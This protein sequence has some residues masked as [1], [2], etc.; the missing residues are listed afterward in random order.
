MISHFHDDFPFNHNSSW[1]T[2]S[3]A[4]GTGAYEYYPPSKDGAWINTSRE[5]KRIQ[6]YQHHYS[7]LTELE[8]L[9]VMGQLASEYWLGKYGQADFLGCTSYRRYLLTDFYER[10]ETKQTIK[11]AGKIVD[12][13]ND[14]DLQR[15]SFKPSEKNIGD[16]SSDKYKNAALELF[17][18]YDVITNIPSTLDC[19]IEQQ[20]LESQPKLYWDLFKG[21]IYE[22]FP[23][24]RDKINWF[25]TSVINFETCYIMRKQMFKKY[26]SELFEL[27]EYIWMRSN[28][29]PIE[30]TT[31]EPN[32]WRYPG[33]LGERFLP[34]FIH[35]NS[36]KP[37]YVPLVV[38][39]DR[40]TQFI[41]GVPSL[42]VRKDNE[43]MLE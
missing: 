28:P 22:L 4:G 27:L 34:F 20:Y 36:L 42:T 32:P 38:F 43:D 21:G 17:K 39:E 19:S 6:E 2:A 15:I 5:Q 31:S 8:F 7:H 40:N 30:Q 33:Y 12:Y 1:M 35:A 13:S 10:K 41:R 23:D 3:F 16:I 24:Y 14:N 37:A 26:A 25:D 11:I 18:T 29:Y 9:K